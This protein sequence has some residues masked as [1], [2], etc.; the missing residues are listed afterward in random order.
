MDTHK[1]LVHRPGGARDAPWRGEVVSVAAFWSGALGERWAAV[2]EAPGLE[3][4]LF[5]PADFV[6]ERSEPLLEDAARKL[7]RDGLSA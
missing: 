4:P 7:V 2:P 5:A 3:A 6:F 1:Q